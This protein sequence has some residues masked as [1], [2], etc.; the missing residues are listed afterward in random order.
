MLST[1]N[2]ELD[3]LFGIKMEETLTCDELDSSAMEVDGETQPMGV[4]PP[5]ITS[6][7]H[8]KL[9]CNIQGGSDVKS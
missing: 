9:V 6:D 8:R 7:L 1:S 4:E 2:P 5:V 3:D